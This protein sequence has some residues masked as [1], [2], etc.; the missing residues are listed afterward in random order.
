M[1]KP[2]IVL[3][4]IA[5]AP[6]AFAEAFIT[7]DGQP[8]AEIVVAENA[9]R[10]TRLAAQELQDDLKK[11]SGAHL[12]IVTA[13][14]GSAAKIFVGRSGHTDALKLKTDDLKDG[15]YRLAS[16]DDWLAL[17]GEDTE[18]APIE[19]WAR[20]NAQIVEGSPLREWRASTRSLWNLPNVLIYKNRFHIPGETG[21]PNAARTATKMKP[22]EVWAE[23]ERGSF[24][25][26]CGFLHKL[27]ARWYAPGEIGEV[28][29][30]L[31]TIALPKLEETVRPDFPIRRFNVRFGVHG[32]AMARW[33]MRLGA[34]D[35]YGIEA[36][37]GMDTITDNGETF[38]AHPEWFSLYGGKR[39]YQRGANNHLCYS[40]E[41]LIAETVRY[42]REVFDR[43]KFEMV[44]VMPPDGYTAICQC[45]LCAGKDSP[46]RP[47]P[48]L[49]SDY[50][51]GFVNRVAKEVRKTHPDKKVMNCAYGI[52]TLPPLKIDKLEPNVVV[53]IVGGRRPMSNKP[54]QQAEFRVLRES[55]VRKTSNPIIFFEN[56]PFTDRGWYL[57]SFTPHT[58]GASINATKGISQGEDIWLSVLQ[59]FEKEQGLGLNHFMV[60]FTQRMYWGGKGADADA[61][62]REYVRLFYGPAE[63]EM[64]AFFDYC[65][66]NWQ[67]ME[68]QKDKADKALALFEKAKAKADAAS[69]Y[70]K[71][72]GMI[73]DYLK[74]LR[75][76]SAQLGKLRGPLPTLR[77]VG[78]PKAKPVIDGELDDDAWSNCPAA[79]VV[80]LRE[81]QTGRQPVFG[82][83]VK[84]AWLGNDLY[85]AIRCDEH[86]GEKPNIG[87]T[88]KDD[89]ALWYGDAIEVLIETEAHSYYQIAVS[90]SG[91]VCD[92]DRGAE[93]AKWFT[94]D[95][96]A[97]VATRIEDDHWTVEMRLP[98]RP[99]ENDPLNQ[100]VGHHPTRSLPWHIN[101]CRQRVRDDGTELSAFSPTGSDGFHNVMKLATFF[102]G[103][104]FEFDHGPA[105]DDFL[106]AM[107][108]V[109]DLA[110]A[111]KRAEA[112][113]ACIA[114]AERKCTDLQKSHALE[115][116]AGFARGQTKLELAEQLI[117]R[118]PIPAA[119]K[120]ARMQHLLDQFKAP[121]VVAEFA[122]EDIGKWPFWK[123]GDGFFGRGRAHVITKNGKEAEADLSRALE[124]TSDARIRDEAALN[125]AQ[126]YEASLRDETRALATYSRVVDGVKQPGS[127]TQFYALHG[128]AGILSKRGKHDDALAVLRR[129]DPAKQQGFW[130]W[131][132][133]LW[134]GDALRAAKRL[135]EA[136]AAYE[137]VANDASA[138]AR[139]Q[140][141]AA[142][143]I[144]AMK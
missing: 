20:S 131:Q 122:T 119:Q 94:W 144:E 70:G 107:R 18:F 29:P 120:S 140:K 71:R 45:P 137:S 57:P 134:Q 93:P 143:Q 116:A 117:A 3:A 130:K 78:S 33:A 136:R 28:M 87:T 61:V 43:Y 104:S 135:G 22:L 47:Q 52:Y 25:A 21:L 65:E 59:Q 24:N 23:D 58:I 41:E 10:T 84:A 27:G 141:H 4:C 56:Y 14:T 110:R 53:S 51:W 102:D 97:E 60:Y 103:N 69:I 96:K 5:A 26:V 16:G 49:A 76:K 42:V 19:P 36:A 129:V 74:G 67:E 81:L 121:Q 82:T 98:V 89:S 1:M 9:R 105:D 68:K 100:V 77:L 15:A 139:L 118:I 95:A 138:D 85:F 108:V 12:P 80:R 6:P 73:D 128:M 17:L 2:L 75:N 126:N 90:P 44:S 40:N 133:I 88:K 37:H 30:S 127:A 113:D 46:E 124:W 32:E 64:N 99:D 38:A 123:R 62:F 109:G 50:V 39:R 142:S 101:V 111:G 114:A 66:A 106:E 63:A 31:K 132:F 86:R 112:L 11:I 54:E 8:R 91:A 83:T 79:A 48:G 34:R 55:W 13:P 115:L 7:K 35:P 125:L 92:L 72:L